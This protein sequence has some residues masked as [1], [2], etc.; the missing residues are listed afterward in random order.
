MVFQ[1]HDS[2]LC[3]FWESN[4]APHLSRRVS[5]FRHSLAAC[6]RLSQVS[7]VYAI[8]KM[9]AGRRSDKVPKRKLTRTIR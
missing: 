9:T 4:G 3:W 7:F 2:F 8:V 1:R 5:L 6:L